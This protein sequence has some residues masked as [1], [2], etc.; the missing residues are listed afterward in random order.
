M[1]LSALLG[2]PR[3]SSLLGGALAS[4]RVH[5]AYLFAGPPGVGKTLAAKLLAQALNCESPAAVDLAKRGAFLDEPCGACPSCRRISDDVKRH[6]HPLVLWV[7]T[8]AAMQA[9][10]LY[11]PEGERSASRAVGVRL[12]RELVIPR[13]ALKAMGGRRKVCIVRDVE[14]TEAAQNSFLKTLEEPPPDTTFVLLSSMPDALKATIRSRCLRVTFQPLPLEL[15]AERV[16]KA[17]GLGAEEARLLAALAGG[18]L[19]AA[20]EIDPK[21][22]AKRREWIAA[23]SRLA[24]DDYAGWLGLASALGDRPTAADAT[25]LLDTCETWMHDVMRVAAGAEPSVNVDLAREA[26]ALADRLG[27]EGSLF[28]LG[29]L[30]RARHAIDGNAQPRLQLERAFLAFCGIEALSLASEAA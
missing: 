13:L 29:V 18:S 14:M 12:I 6:A 25:E 22:L 4:G 27:V 30:E 8:E 28:R 19:G 10:G 15:V 3:A 9:A 11:Q 24:G 1:S 21:T 7:D 5:H 20:L 23:F 16:Q 17:R 2:Q 26:G